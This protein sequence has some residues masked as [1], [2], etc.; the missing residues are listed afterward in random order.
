LFSRPAI[1]NAVFHLLAVTV[2]LLGSA[3]V[4]CHSD[5]IVGAT[6]TIDLPLRGSVSD[7]E[8]RT[9]YKRPTTIPFPAYNPY[10][11]QKNI[12][13]KKLYFDS[14]LSHGK[15]LSCASCHSPGYAW[16]DGQPTSVGHLMKRL[17]RRSP[18]ILNLAYGQIYMWDGRAESL[19][20]QALGPLQEALEMAMPLD[21]LLT[22][23]QAIDEYHQLFEA[24]FPGE[25]ITS[26]NVAKAIATF[27]RTLISGRA[28]FDAWIEGDENAISEPAKR[29]FRL[30]NTKAQCAGCHSGWNLTDDSFHDTGLASADIG[31]G[32]FLPDVVKSQHAFKTPGLREIT[33][34][35]PY[36]HDGSIPTLEDVIDHYDKGGIQRKSRSEL[37]KPLDLTNNEKADLLAFMQTLTS[38]MEPTTFPVFPR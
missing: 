9:S 16:A 22:Q 26:K 7:A 36:M 12:L 33:R 34:R 23:I 1:D 10:T 2:A 3:I 25:G 6:R 21:D 8:I 14:R 35:A 28:P 11:V 18:T 13:G 38:D 31:R 4:P 27:E 29:G 17:A 24:A 37:I 19:E 30:F 20:E 15:L 5:A 32:K